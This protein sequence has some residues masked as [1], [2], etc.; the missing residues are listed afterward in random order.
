MAA[1]L[2]TGRA[3]LSHRDAAALHGIRPPHHG[4]IDV[5]AS[6]KRASSRGIRAHQS[7]V[8]LRRDAVTVRGI[9]TT[10]VARTLADLADVVPPHQLE[11]ALNEA[12]R[13]KLLDLGALEEVAARTR[14]R[15][16]PGPA[17][18]RQAL[19]RLTRE[20][21]RVTRSELEDRFLALLD[22]HDLPR[23]RTNVTVEGFEVDAHWP[24]HRLVVE[25]D[26]W[27]WHRTRDAFER[28]HR[29]T[30]VLAD[31]G[32]TVRRFTHRQV[33]DEPDAVA[34]SLRR[35]LP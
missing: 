35:L 1:V 18:L 8:L 7:R 4:P 30:T 21:A 19:D 27:E 33:A 11:K 25:L 13:L 3:L 34:A 32:L 5:T 16:G 20:G 26:G 17:A 10:T 23:P 9:P 2:A 28:D 15:R 29:R 22:A 12:E 31:A 24:Q 14:H 6:G